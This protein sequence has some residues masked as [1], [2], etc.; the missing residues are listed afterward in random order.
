MSLPEE[1]KTAIISNGL[2]FVRAITDAYGADRGM[3]LWEQ[4]ASVLD[5]NIKGEMFFAMLTGAYNDQIKL[6]GV[7]N[8]GSS[9]AISCIKE[10]RQWTGMGLK[11]AKDTYDRLRDHRDPFS[12]PRPEMITVKPEDHARAVT[13]LRM[14]GFTI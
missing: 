14:V 10:I 3:A 6:R 7:T 5:P 1:H 4:I 12:A 8:G 2:H 13:G 11:E 9:N